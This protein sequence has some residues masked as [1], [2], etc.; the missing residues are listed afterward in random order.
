MNRLNVLVRC[1]GYTVF[2]S[3][4]SSFGVLAG[5][6]MSQWHA[7]APD[8]IFSGTLG[9][10]LIGFTCGIIF[11]QFPRV[12]MVGLPLAMSPFLFTFSPLLGKIVLGVTN[13][14]TLD[15]LKIS[16][17]G[18]LTLFLVTLPFTIIVWLT[19]D[20]YAT[21][22]ARISKEAIELRCYVV[23]SNPDGSKMVGVELA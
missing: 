3:S 18:G 12:N 7:Y 23:V 22:A 5:L 15:L 16:L 10:T 8:I 1:I 21:A 4:F 11:T 2:I 13:V 19:L 14:S 9:G 20:Q 17:V 6:R